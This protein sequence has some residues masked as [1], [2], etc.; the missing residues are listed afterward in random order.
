MAGKQTPQTLPENTETDETK[1]DDT[2]G[3]ESTTAA[4]DAAAKKKAE[5]EAKA[6]KAAKAKA[7]REAKKAK[8]EA[9]AEA[10]ESTSSTNVVD[11]VDEDPDEPKEPSPWMPVPMMSDGEMQV[12]AINISAF[13]RSGVLLRFRVCGELTG[14]VI[15]VE[16]MHYK[17]QVGELR[18]A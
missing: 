2:V 14:K 12:E 16:K 17:A 1:V 11:V 5:A 13:Q 18:A 6:A 15:F 3:T 4:D 10:A 8:A 7:A 9:E